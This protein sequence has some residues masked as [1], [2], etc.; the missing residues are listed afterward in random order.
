MFVVRFRLFCF[1][2]LFF[3]LLAVFGGTCGARLR[4]SDVGE[5]LARMWRASTPTLVPPRLWR[6]PPRCAA[7]VARGGSTTARVGGGVSAIAV[8]ALGS[9]TVTHRWHS[10]AQAGRVD[11]PQHSEDVAGA[12]ACAELVLVFACITQHDA[13]SSLRRQLAVGA[14][15][16]SPAAVAHSVS[17]CGLR[18]IRMAGATCSLESAELDEHCLRCNAGKSERV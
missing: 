10:D 13:A 1:S 12:F 9:S 2:F 15:P 4:M 14:L 3:F 8:L 5:S 6:V 18:F 16:W 7:Q 11:G 17:D